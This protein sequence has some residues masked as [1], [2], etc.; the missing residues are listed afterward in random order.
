MNTQQTEF[1]P[2]PNRSSRDNREISAIVVHYTGSMH[3]DGTISWFQNPQA[4][5][6][7]HYVIGRDGRIV[8][9]V[10]DKDVA[11]HAGVSELEGRPH[12]N[13]FSIGIE[14]VGT[15]DSGFTDRQM[16]ALYSLIETLVGEYS[17]PPWRVVGHLHVA[18]NRKIDPDG[19]N[20]QFNWT[21]VRAVANAALHA[22]KEKKV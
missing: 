9:M 3:I 19:Y 12:V 14:L 22:Q 20:K 11:W 6:S 16:E 10:K 7:A 2:S 8:Q 1:I 17:V 18:P 21:K 4:R 13:S 5:V 15:H